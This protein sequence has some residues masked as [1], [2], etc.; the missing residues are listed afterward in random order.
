M[1]NSTKTAL[2]II[3]QR[4]NESNEPA[5]A[6]WVEI[7]NEVIAFGITGEQMQRELNAGVESGYLI[8]RR[9]LNGDIYL[10]GNGEQSTI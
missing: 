9:G 10:R 6:M 1:N 4:E 5:F 8:K 7:Y 3:E 2:A